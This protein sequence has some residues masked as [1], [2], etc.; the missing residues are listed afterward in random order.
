MDERQLQQLMADPLTSI[1]QH[2][3]FRD[4][5]WEVIPLEEV[6]YC[7]ALSGKNQER[8]MRLMI[9]IAL[10]DVPTATRGGLARKRSKSATR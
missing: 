5:P 3:L 8:A 10:G 1:A 9:V 2:E 4:A 7:D 6:L